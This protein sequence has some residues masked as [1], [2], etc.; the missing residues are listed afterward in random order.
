[1]K[2]EAISCRNGEGPGWTKEREDKH[3]R[4]GPAQARLWFLRFLKD[5]QR[6][7]PGFSAL[8]RQSAFLL[9]GRSLSG[10]QGNLIIF[11]NLH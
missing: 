6:H 2:T 11:K 5:A 1:M 7:I 3:V 10:C 8:P 4:Q 9:L